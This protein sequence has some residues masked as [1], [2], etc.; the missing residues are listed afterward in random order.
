MR[1]RVWVAVLAAALSMPGA[2]WAQDGSFNPRTLTPFSA[3][4]AEDANDPRRAPIL[5]IDQDALYA[6]SA[7]GRRAQAELEAAASALS[8]ENDRIAA[9]LTREEHDLTEARRTLPA[10]EF[11]PLADAFD[12]KAQTA[13][14]TALEAARALSRR[15]EQERRVFIDSSLPAFGI[16]MRERGAQVV[17]DRR[18]VLVSLDAVDI[19]AEMIQSLDAA[20]GDGTRWP[21]DET[22]VP[23]VD[24]AEISSGA[25]DMPQV[26][27]PN[28]ENRETPAVAPLVA[29]QIAPQIAP[30]SMPVSPP[31]Q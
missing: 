17:L 31:G 14:R 25:E 30:L 2:L 28:G 16:L 27:A 11:A 3:G 18:S 19:T 24:R 9:E 10:V 21:R 1:G 13:R 22:G 6:G 23:V 5:T 15:A 7:W 4:Q 8:A 29:P 12:E 26:V 20:L